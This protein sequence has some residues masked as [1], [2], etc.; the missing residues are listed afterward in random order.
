MSSRRSA[1]IAI[2]DASHKDAMEFA[3]A[4]TDHWKSEDTMHRAQS[5]NS[6]LFWYRPS[7]L[8]LNGIFN[9][10]VSSGG[11]EPGLINGVAA[12]KRCPFFSLGNP[13]FEIL[14]PDKGFCNLV[15][16]NLNEFK[17][18]SGTT[19]EDLDHT[20]RI[21]SRANY[22]QTCVNLDDGVLQ[23]AWEENNRFLRLCGVGLTGVLCYNPTDEEF[24]RFRTIAREST[25]EMADE[26]GLPRAK[27]VTTIK[28]SGTLSKIMGTV[29]NGEVSEGI[30]KPLGK[31]IFNNVIF[32]AHD[33]IVE[34]ARNAG[35]KVVPNPYEP[36]NSFL[37]TMPV[38]YDNMDFEKKI[39]DDGQT[40]FVNTDS[41]V[42]QLE[43]YKRVMQLYVDFNCSVTISY[44][45]SEISDIVNWLHEN[46]DHYVGVS[47]LFRTDPTKTAKDLGF[48]YLPQEVVS[49][50]VW[51]AY[52]DSI[53]PIDVS[54][55]ANIKPKRISKSQKAESRMVEMEME[56]EA[57]IEAMDERCAGGQCPV[58]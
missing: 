51:H 11:S 44:D 58:R 32:G 30:H 33:G 41:A 6:L 2:V 26:L 57:A 49:E 4:K 9:T 7:K 10:I 28:P 24:I 23:S 34:I 17:K 16:V 5:N 52:N 15:E 3:T 8:E 36:D 42:T 12:Q 48:L 47:F 31:Y 21:I 56:Q 14:L 1:E 13:C 53:K 45:K 39:L 19:P 43:R 37:I 27:A 54:E 22:R 29:E 18:G 46:W 35:Y 25:F 38:K 55:F 40:V 50:G 20:I